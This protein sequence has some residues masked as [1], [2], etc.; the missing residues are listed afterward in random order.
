M[1]VRSRQFTGRIVTVANSKIFDEPVY[2]YSRDFPF[3]WEELTVPV[4]YKSDRGRAEQMLLDATRRHALSREQLTREAL[5]H[6]RRQYLVNVEDL[7]PR[8]FYRLTDNWL[9]LTVRF[10]VKAYG[11]REVKDAMSREILTAFEDAGI[12]VASATFEVVGLPP[13]QVRNGNA[14]STDNRHT[15]ADG[16]TLEKG[17]E[18]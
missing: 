6:M 1:W 14:P 5:D 3:I 18:H 12:G 15:G 17:S 7:E 10:L 8:V 13:L 9:E 4:T 11:V 2:N 16:S